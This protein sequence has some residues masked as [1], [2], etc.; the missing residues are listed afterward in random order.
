MLKEEIPC[1]AAR[2]LSKSLEKSGSI[3]YSGHESIRQHDV[4]FMGLNPGGEGGMSIGC[5]LK[6]VLSQDQN[7]FMDEDWSNNARSY[8]PGEAPLQRRVR[9]LF[10]HLGFDPRTV[11]STNLI[12]YRSRDASGVSSAQ[13]DEC[14]PVHD[15]LLSIVK[16]HLIL[17]HG[18]SSFS[19]YAY[20]HSKF[21]GE[22]C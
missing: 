12:F 20:L 17:V 14:W 5:R 19:P 7:A 2:A 21:G 11:P 1:V 13:A 9:W 3:L 4:Y 6:E 18:N 16:P 10:E 8:K 15:A 22:Q